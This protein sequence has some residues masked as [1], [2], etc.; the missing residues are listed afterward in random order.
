MPVYRFAIIISCKPKSN[1]EILDAADALGAAGCI[2]ASL[3]GHAEGMELHFDRSAKSLQAAIGTA[4]ASVESA[5]FKV[6]RVEMEREAI[7]V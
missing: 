4:I 5:G 2:D 1:E 7:P 3:R 6:L